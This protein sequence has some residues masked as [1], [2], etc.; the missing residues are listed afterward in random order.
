MTLES[1]DSNNT[2]GLSRDVEGGEAVRVGERLRK[3][4]IQK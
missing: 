1:D 3:I 2:V 4:L